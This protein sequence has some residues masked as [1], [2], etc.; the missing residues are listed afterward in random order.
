MKVEQT[1]PEVASE[2]AKIL[3]DKNAS[4]A[5]KKVAASALNQAPDKKKYVVVTSIDCEGLK[6]RPHVE[7]GKAVP[8]GIPSEDIKALLAS[9]DIKEL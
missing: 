8:E 5:M 7:K 1:S 3:R 2:A 4:P 6:G 9:G